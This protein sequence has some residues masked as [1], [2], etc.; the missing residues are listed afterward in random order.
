MNIKQLFEKFKPE[1][2][3]NDEPRPYQEGFAD[4]VKAAIAAMFPVVEL[5]DLPPEDCTVM[6]LRA[7][8]DWW[9]LWWDAKDRCFRACGSSQRFSYWSFDQ[10]RRCP[11]PSELGVDS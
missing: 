4:G 3:F 11:T 2:Y 1:Y 9:P 7:C 8:G 10:I 6:G 5:K